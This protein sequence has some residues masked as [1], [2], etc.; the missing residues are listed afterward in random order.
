[1]ATVPRVF[2]RL[3]EAALWSSCISMSTSVRAIVF[4]YQALELGRLHL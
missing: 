4:T 1:M 3:A 2:V